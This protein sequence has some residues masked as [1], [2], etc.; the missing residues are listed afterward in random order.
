MNDIQLSIFMTYDADP[1]GAVHYPPIR[2]EKSWKG[3]ELAPDI[4]DFF[5]TYPIPYTAFIRCD[6]QIRDYFGKATGFLEE[7]LSFLSQIER[8]GVEIGW[9][10][11]LYEVKE[12]NYQ[13]IQDPQ[14]AVHQLNQ[15]YEELKAQGFHLTSVRLGECWHSN[16]T[17]IALESLGIKVDSTALPGRYRKDDYYFIDWQNTPNQPYFPS[18]IDY[19][20][21][22]EQ[23]PLNILEVPMTTIPIKASYDD[24][25]ILRYLNLTYHPEIFNEALDSFLDGIM[26]QD[27]KNFSLVTIFHTDE[28]L[29]K[30]STALYKSGID[31]LKKN[32]EYLLQ[33]LSNHKIGYS[34]KCLRQA[35]VPC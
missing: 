22:N 16:E 18:K 23:D 8:E 33:T 7:H 13:P 31:T 17:M 14:K 25:P 9:H 30:K 12:G 2:N 35:V 1:D 29:N 10:P 6:D 21:S 4:H 5:S 34:F 27:E 20:C 3:F 28:I 32:F 19:R 11:H 15:V 24:K 26:T